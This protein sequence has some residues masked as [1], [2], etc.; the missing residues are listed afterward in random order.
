ML[1]WW[2]FELEWVKYYYNIYLILFALL[3]QLSENG[4]FLVGLSLYFYCP[5]LGEV[6]SPRQ[7]G[8]TSVLL[9]PSLSPPLLPHQHCGLWCLCTS[10][11]CSLYCYVSAVNL[12]GAMS[13]GNLQTQLNLRSFY[14]PFPPPSLG[15]NASPQGHIKF[16]TELLQSLH[17]ILI[18]W[19]FKPGAMFCS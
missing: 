11:V 5:A 18:F 8:W 14:S 7:S 4:K 12:H 6:P 15:L 9:S 2:Y 13:Y 3:M 16:Y 10:T 1:E 17:R 19:M